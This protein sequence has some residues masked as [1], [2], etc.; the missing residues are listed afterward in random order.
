VFDPCPLGASK[1]IRRAVYEGFLDSFANTPI[2]VRKSDV[3]ST[4]E[5][6]QSAV[7]LHVRRVSADGAGD[8]KSLGNGSAPGIPTGTAGIVRSQVSFRTFDAN[9]LL[10]PQVSVH[11]IEPPRRQQERSR[12]RA[13]FQL[14]EE[15]HPAAACRRATLKAAE[16]RRKRSEVD[17]S[18]RAQTLVAQAEASVRDAGPWK[19]GPY[20]AERQSAGGGACPA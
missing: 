6:N 19:L 16:D 12:F 8:N 2:P 7:E 4:S 20:G 15:E 11:R 1:R 3:F 9:G 17:R 13:G 18:N 5:A 10:L 14:Q